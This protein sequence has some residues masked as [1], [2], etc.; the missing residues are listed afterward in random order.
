MSERERRGDELAEPRLPAFLRDPLGVV[1]RRW[2]SMVLV[3]LGL[4]MAGAAAVELRFTPSYKA[5]A[6]VLVSSQQFRENLLPSSVAKNGAFDKISAM[7]GETLASENLAALIERLG[8]YPDLRTSL[9]PEELVSIM[10]KMVAIEAQPSVGPQPLYETAAVFA[11]SFRYDR[12]DLAAATANELAAAFVESGVRLRRQQSQLA[13]E[14]LRSRL[15]ATAAAL[16]QSEAA[17]EDFRRQHRAQLALGNTDELEESLAQLRARLAQQRASYTDAHPNVSSLNRELSNLSGQLGSIHARR[18]E[19]AALERRVVA[20]R[21]AQRDA[22]ERVQ[23]AD[24]SERLESAGE[25]GIAAVLDRAVA[26]L[27]PERTRGKLLL[28][29]LVLSLGS[30]AATGLLLELRDPVVVA[31]DQLADFALPLLGGVP[32]IR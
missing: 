2:P 4:L 7:T 29:V 23:E 18:E 32:P 9:S 21:R 19:L 12:P 30:A 22:L 16:A 6:T 17:V 10:R 1:R 8:L 28:A 5:R 14:L 3:F 13:S 11:I 26:P 24:L 27:Q 25:G 31:E 15:E 20:A